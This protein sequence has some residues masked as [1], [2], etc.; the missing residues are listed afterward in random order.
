MAQGGFRLKPQALRDPTVVTV[1]LGA[2]LFAATELTGR[3]GV[4]MV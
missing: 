2:L 3:A 1:N 4:F